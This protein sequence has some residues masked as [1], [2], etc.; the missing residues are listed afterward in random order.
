MNRRE[1]VRF[2]GNGV[3]VIGASAFLLA[4]EDET[5][6]PNGDNPAAAP[7]ASG[8]QVIYATNV[9]GDHSHTF[10]IE[11][12]D[13]ATP[14]TAGVSGPTSSGEGHTHD[15]MVSMAELQMVGAGQ[16]VKVTTSSAGGHTHVLTLV[17]LA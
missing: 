6:T 16:T 5:G 14:P 13:I 2:C 12:A 3:I 1:F 10:G 15:V 17:K 11:M 8:T 4:C 7:K 9:V